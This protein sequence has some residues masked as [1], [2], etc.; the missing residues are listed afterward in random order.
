M[1]VTRCRSP[2]LQQAVQLGMQ[3]KNWTVPVQVSANNW[4]DH[5]VLQVPVRQ[6]VTQGNAG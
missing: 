1:I 3:L 2:C 5:G 6:R 4:L